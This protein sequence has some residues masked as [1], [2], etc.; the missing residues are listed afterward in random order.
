ML[1]YTRLAIIVVGLVGVAA[2]EKDNLESPDAG[3]S[4]STNANC[5]MEKA[6][7]CDIEGDKTCVECLPNGDVSACAG[8]TP[9]CD[10]SRS[11]R[12]CKQHSDCASDA[13]L[14]DGS[15]AMESQVVYLKE[16]G[17]GSACSR[18]APCGSYDTAVALLASQRPILRI[19]GSI[20]NAEVSFNGGRLTFLGDN[21]GSS[22]Q[23]GGTSGARSMLTLSTGAR[24]EIY[25]VALRN[26]RDEGI[27][28]TGT[29]SVTLVR[30]SVE[31]AMKEGILSDG[32]VVL[33]QSAV[34]GSKDA[35][36]RG[37]N[38]RNGELVIDRS[39]I[40]TNEG[41][42][43]LVGDGAKFTV[44]NSFLVGN[45]TA[46]AFSTINP[47]DDSKIEF[48]TVVDNAGAGGST[49]A[50]GIV[51]D[52]NN[53]S[54]RYN[55]LYRN[56]GGTGGGVQR[57]GNCVFTG[58]FEMAAGAADDTLKF[59][60]ETSNPKDYHLTA[61]SPSSVRAVAGVVCDG[62]KDFDGDERPQGAGCDLGA[63]E[64]K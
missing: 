14:P 23:G 29:S 56:T 30:S 64:V 39:R 11:C 36:R 18:T 50:G 10:T 57:L 20:S 62:L 51:C 35:N 49:A 12:A 1:A 6:M 34:I 27:V 48:N 54:A 24:L 8:T 19:S 15:C 59:K 53:V 52:D 13:C 28:V 21:A 63:D 25:D 32:R 42:G 4:C 2:C 43:V 60:S 41:G 38:A 47:N 33:L 46:G 61:A 16:G 22:L 45:K 37:I 5:T 3:F 17:Q 26:S 55:I 31:G 7:V 58:S 9:V 44:T 40:A